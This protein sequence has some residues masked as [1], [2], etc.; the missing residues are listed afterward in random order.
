M[1]NNLFGTDGIRRTI[2]IPPLCAQNLPKLGYAIGQWTH[3]YY[4]KN[5]HI[6]IAHD[7]RGS[8][9]FVKA[10]LK[11]GLLQHAL[12]IHDAHVLPT[13]AVCQLTSQEDIFNLGIVI[14]ASHNPY[15]DNGI[16]L[17]DGKQGKLSLH[18]ELAISQ[19]FFC[20]SKTTP[21]YMNLG[22]DIP[23]LYGR[24]QYIDTITK[25]F[26]NNFLRNKK[27]VL[28]CA[29]G[30]TYLVAPTI[31]R[32]LGADVITIN[33]Q[34]NG[35]NINENCGVLYPHQLQKAVI[36]NNAN[37]GF[38][39]D[40][41]GDRVMA[42]NKNG[43]LKDGDDLLVLLLEHPLYN[44]EHT[45]V[46]TIMTNQGLEVHLQKNNKQL[47]RTAVGDKYVA[48]QLEQHQLT[49]GAEQSGHIILRDYLN[50]GDGI[51]TALR[52]LESINYTYNY[53]LLTFKKFPQILINVPVSQKK[54]LAAIPL[55]NVIDYHK[56]QLTNGRLIV[57]YSGTENV[58]RVMVENDDVQ[59]AQLIGTALSQ[60]LAEQLG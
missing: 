56:A 33:N 41:D 35:T 34:P 47:I 37:I 13:P 57:R 60:A 20:S 58:L 25:H 48:E 38:A 52:I 39:F 28:D 44:K 30:A 23:F 12:T 32:Q 5:P 9:S 53:D 22:N 31:F 43:E 19:L 49:L 55:V 4:G 21:N 17:I 36:D 1:N 26:P 45:V 15:Q 29:H 6:L 11:A 2:G 7:T 3:N 27:I 59:Q 18:H 46:G 14:S 50:T 16:K 8:C 51:F 40:G 54:D 24:Q 42:V 10:S